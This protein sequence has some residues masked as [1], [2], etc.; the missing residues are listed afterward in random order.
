MEVIT[1]QIIQKPIS[2]IYSGL[3]QNLT[4]IV[5]W[6]YSVW[7][8]TAILC[9]TQVVAGRCTDSWLLIIIQRLLQLLYPLSPGK[10]GSMTSTFSE[11]FDHLN[12]TLN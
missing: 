4:M 5:D 8:Q 2:C 7:L 1:F 3:K 11:I 12:A 9:V 10:G 6:C